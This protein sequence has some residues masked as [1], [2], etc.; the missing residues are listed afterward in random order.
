MAEPG[1]FERAKKF[2][3]GAEGR[4]QT[5]HW[6]HWLQHPKVQERLNVLTTGEPN[7][8]R[9]CAFVER[10]FPIPA[11]RTERVD[12]VLTLGC[13]NGEFERGL[14]QYHFASIHEGIDIS[15]HATAEAA[16]LA[17]EAGLDHIR[18]RALDFNTMELPDEAYDVVFGISSVHHVAR[19]ER[20]FEQVARGLKPGGLFLLDEFVGPS[21]FQWTDDQ[22]AITNEGLSGLPSDLRRHVRTGATVERIPRPTIAEMN[23]GDPSEAIR[24]AEILPLLPK[25]FDVLEVKGYG[26]TILHLLLEGITGNFVEAD[27][28]SMEWLRSFFDLEDRLI[29]AGRL[30]HDFA[31]IIARKKVK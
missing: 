10:Y 22:L 3:E 1:S 30:H 14:S 4:W 28:R 23:A 16:R 6:E 31:H 7:K 13:G 29:S 12:R 17:R 18:Y 8:D 5:T 15:E 24:S 21:Q 20:L 26:G 19:L 27:P 11:G 9:Y 25:Y 2:W